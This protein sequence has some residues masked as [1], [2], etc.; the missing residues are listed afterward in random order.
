M[1]VSSG[2]VICELILFV[3]DFWKGSQTTKR[4]KRSRLPPSATGIK[5]RGGE[6]VFQACKNCAVNF[7]LTKQEKNK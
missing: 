2:N 7:I 4:F 3:S 5:S 6:A 1:L